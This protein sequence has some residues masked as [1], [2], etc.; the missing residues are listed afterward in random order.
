MECGEYFR[1]QCFI[2]LATNDGRLMKSLV[3]VHVNSWQSGGE[4]GTD[5]PIRLPECSR[6]TQRRAHSALRSWTCQRIPEPLMR[7]AVIGLPALSMAPEPIKSPRW[8]SVA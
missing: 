8:R 2:S 7:A 6:K 1:T 3:R 4:S 5:S